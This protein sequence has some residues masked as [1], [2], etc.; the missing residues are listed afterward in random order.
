MVVSPIAVLLLPFAAW[1]VLASAKIGREAWAGRREEKRRAG[2]AAA[3]S[4]LGLTGRVDDHALEILADAGFAILRRGR[5]PSYFYCLN[6]KPEGTS[7]IL[8]FDFSYQARGDGADDESMVVRQTV[9]A[10]FYPKGGLPRFELRPKGLLRKI[11]TALVGQKIDFKS[12]PDFSRSYLLRGPSEGAIRRIFRLN[13][14]EYF[15]NHKGWWAEANGMWLILYRP[16]RLL[17][18]EELPGFIDDA[19]LLLWALPR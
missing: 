1:A 18:P 14:L 2:I 9:A 16:G 7:G 15:E 11:G 3:V 6:R 13:L 5:S 8:L 17:Q 4:R 12:H 19:R 10:L